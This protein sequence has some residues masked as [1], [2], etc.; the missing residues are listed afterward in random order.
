MKTLFIIDELEF[1][2]FEFNKL[3]TSFWLNVE[4]LRRS[5]SVFVAT[6][7]M[8]NVKN[9][10]PYCFCAK[11]YMQNGELL[12]DN[13]LENIAV[14]DFEIVFFR[15]DPP[16]NMEYINATHILSMA[17]KKRTI[18]INS[19][20]AIRNKNEKLY[21]NEFPQIAPNNVVTSNPKLIRSFLKENNEIVIKPLNRCFSSG[22]FYLCHGDKNTNTIIN[23]ATEN[24]K[25][26]VMVQEYLPEIKE[27]DKRLIFICGEILDYSVQKVATNDDFKFNEH[28]DAN[29]KMTKLT[30]D[31]KEI[32]N[33]I[34]EKLLDDGVVMAGLDTIGGKIIEIN[35]TSPCFFIKEINLIYGI[36]LEKIIVDKIENY[37]LKNKKQDQISVFTKC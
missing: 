11:S 22:V 9:A 30:K 6:K 25:T 32:E 33:I 29:L 35:I 31:E 12:K 8:L 24:G 17:D 13:L 36:S 26:A 27:G 37:I 7:N 2:Y 16:V 23:T 20:E 5:Y 34:S 18:I 10:K 15:P 14:E 3:V 19:A 28:C 4:F 21:I 1:K